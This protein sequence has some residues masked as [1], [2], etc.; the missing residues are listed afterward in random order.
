VVENAAIKPQ[1]EE[2]LMFQRCSAIRAILFCLL[3][4]GVIWAQVDT[5]VIT[6]T[7]SDQ[8]GAVISSA[9]VTITNQFTQISTV[10]NVNEGGG[11]TS[12]P[13]QVGTYSVSATASGFQSQTRTGIV[14]QVQDRFN[15]D[16][17][18]TVGQVSQNVT[19]IDETPALQTETS[20]LGQVITSQTMTDMPLDGRDYTRLAA[21]S[22]GV[23]DATYGSNG[24][25]GGSGFVANG[26]R[27]TLNNFILDG[28]DNNS[29][30]GGENA[31]FTNIDAIQEFKVQTNSFSAEFGRS[32]GAAINV[33]I[34][35]G[36]NN[37][38]GDVFE[39]FR[40]SVL[41]AK[42]YFEAPGST[43]L[44]FKQN[45]FGGILGGPIIRNK[46]F[47]F[48]DYQGTEIRL[49]SPAYSTV[50]TTDEVG[51]D[52]SAAGLPTIY[53]PSTYDPI[54]NTRQP[55]LNN[56]ITTG[57]DTLAQQFLA[58]YP[59]QNQP[60]LT[61]NYL[62]STS[63][64]TAIKQGDA[65]VDYHYSDV[66]QAFFRYT[67]NISMINTS[68]PLPG[69]ANGGTNLTGQHPQ[70]GEGAALGE[71]HTFTPNIINEFRIGFNWVGFKYGGGGVT[72]PANL[73]VPGVV[74]NP[75]ITAI[76]RFQPSG[77]QPVGD[78]GDT[79]TI[80]RSEERQ[81][82]DVV[83]IVRGKQTI[84]VGGEI[85]WSEFNIFQERA[86]SGSFNFS[87]Q[88][89]QNPLDGSGGNS[90]AD[91]LLGLPITST[92]DT[93]V[94]VRNRQH[95]LSG[96]LQDDYR[97]T[98]TLTL[99][100]GVRYDYVSP[101]VSANN[102]QSNFDY[103]TGQLI[104][105]EVNGASRGLVTV[106]HANFAPR[107]GFA[108]KLFKQ[109]VLS[110]AY[111]IFYSG[112]EIKTAAPLQ[113]GY[114]LPFYYQ[115]TFRSD[116][117]T[118]ILT[119][120]GGFPALNVADAPY[121]GVTSLDSRLK[122]PYFQEWNLS[123]QQGLSAA[124]TI[125]VSYAGSKGTHLQSLADRN[126]VETPG[127]GAVQPRR[128][129]PNFGP[130]TSI[131]NRGNSTYNSLQV[132]AEQH[133]SHGLYFL[134]SFTFSKMINDQPEICCNNPFPENS[135]DIP[136]DKGLSDGNQTYRWINSFDYQLPFGKGSKILADSRAAD[137][138]VGGWHFGGIYSLG[139][140]FMFSPYIG[141]DSSNTG[142]QEAVRAELVTQG[143][144]GNLSRGQRKPN[145]WFNANAY[146]V[147]TGYAFGNAGRNTL[148]GP[149]LNN[150]DGSLRKIFAI[151]GVQSV[152]FRA[153]AFNLLNHPSFSQPD[154]YITDGPGATAVVTSTALNNRQIQFA[155]RYRF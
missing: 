109:S 135:W 116:G 57:F 82:T 95:V 99:N 140:G 128:P 32:G 112:Q 150:F 70:N 19:V 61:N 50:P 91:A 131:E 4:T 78:P 138:I 133:V 38:H 3:A 49:P 59:T 139:S 107:V 144:S 104:V 86:P 98:R 117:I 2:L 63:Q 10:V 48:G 9:K 35:S 108:Q 77:Y 29:N 58:L 30:D 143:V 65:R 84:A 142:D 87:G 22:A 39:F 16:I 153:E 148:I 53:D 36:T 18:M 45:Q 110:G 55:F 20:A 151:R 17:K 1:K 51:G 146:T 76:T 69:L 54:T 74:E 154:S 37:Y 21:L 92:I 11:F 26:A 105:A 75:G 27:G 132:K 118:P 68:A 145:N 89:T 34:K 120:S 31:L 111:A 66:D 100:L 41:D 155:L 28:I 8:T 62:G 14:L 42:N 94:T 43:K 44:S 33:V 13:L 130:F 81:I 103:Q 123:I 101:I 149:D 85:R 97:I 40:N 79:P 83:N 25:V 67:T 6:G 113:L 126:Q 115:P 52:F 106:D 121:P 124:T 71:T 47:W 64:S 15:V 7:V 102:Q 122:T 60:G 125:E 119:V 5:A 80:D 127:P 24:N 12:P 56:K 137:L 136:A 147:P 23:I 114:N 134:S 90:I 72:P 129:Y 152:E 93:F 141:Y 73:V 88:F 96:F 46:L